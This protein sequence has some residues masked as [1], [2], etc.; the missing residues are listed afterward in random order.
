MANKIQ[1]SFSSIAGALP[2]TSDNRVVA[3]A[4]TGDK[5]SSV[6]PDKPT[7]VDAGIK[8]FT[9]DLWLT[10]FAPAGLPA[11]VKTK[12]NDAITTALARPQLKE[13]FAKVG[14]SPR[15]TTAADA[16]AFVKADFKKWRKVITE[17]KIKSN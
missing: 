2:F 17:A 12:L 14:A 9:V 5:P 3:L 10:V 13:A 4:T 1:F 11:D 7:V 6:Y 8:G 16:T 15:G